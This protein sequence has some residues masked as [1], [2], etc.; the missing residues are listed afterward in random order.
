MK[1]KKDIR[2]YIKS[3]FWEQ[4]REEL[5]VQNKKV[6]EKIL[7]YTEKNDVQNICIYENMTDEVDTKNIIIE[8][9]RKGKNLYTPQMISETEMI[10]IDNQYE[11]YEDNIDLFIIPWRAFSPSWTRLG[12]GKWY[13]DRF[14]AKGQ[15]KSS[16]KLGICYD[17][18]ILEDIPSN[19]YDID[20]NLII[21]NTDV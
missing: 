7:E 16:K 1:S 8:L 15:Y 17:F 10:L 4:D 6:Q 11:I 21:S 14:L 12:R 5:K 9:E 2:T 19:K 20:M 18:Q 3:L 13:Y